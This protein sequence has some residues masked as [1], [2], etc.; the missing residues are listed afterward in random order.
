MH[1]NVFRLYEHTSARMRI[2]L[3][4]KNNQTHTHT[5][6]KSRTDPMQLPSATTCTTIVLAYA[7][8]SLP[9]LSESALRVCNVLP[10][11]R[12]TLCLMRQRC[13]CREKQKKKGKNARGYKKARNI[14]LANEMNV[15]RM[16][17]VSISVARFRIYIT[18]KHQP[19]APVQPIEVI[20]SSA[21]RFY[22]VPNSPRTLFWVRG[23]D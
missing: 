19:P 7:S 8:C 1:G 12:P 13:N 18:P 20:R 10:L 22:V 17:I 21:I 15:L 3:F 4:T 11:P 23:V 14:S 9:S 16:G 6:I 5:L 2:S